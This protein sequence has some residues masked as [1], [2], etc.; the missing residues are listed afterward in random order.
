MRLVGLSLTASFFLQMTIFLPETYHPILLKQRA[1]RMRKEN[2]EEHGDKYAE[3]E[4]ADFSLH[5]I[6]TRTLARPLVML[7]VEP[8]MITVTIYLSVRLYASALVVL[9]LKLTGPPPLQ[10]VYGLLFVHLSSTRRYQ[11][12]KI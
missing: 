3:L 6:I 9:S 8:I 5:S 4:R 7:V 12:S 10:V 1:K 11:I 2:P